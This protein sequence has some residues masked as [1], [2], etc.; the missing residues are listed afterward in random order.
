M[1][2]ILDAKMT[3]QNAVSE[4]LWECMLPS[5]STEADQDDWDSLQVAVRAFLG[6]DTCNNSCS[7]PKINL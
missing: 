2:K 4:R 6:Y 1:V 3:Q 7:P 5:P